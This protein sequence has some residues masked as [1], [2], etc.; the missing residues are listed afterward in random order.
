VLNTPSA[1][2]TFTGVLTV[3]GGQLGLTA[4][5][6]GVANSLRLSNGAVFGYGA[7]L[8]I[9]SHRPRQQR[10]FRLLRRPEHHLRLCRK[11]YVTERRNT[12]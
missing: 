5:A 4:N 12:S 1:A 11:Q 7:D 3:A 10:H 9:R 6:L 8:T 2:N